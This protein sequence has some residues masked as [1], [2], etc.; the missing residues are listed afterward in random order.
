MGK[1]Y[2]DKVERALQYIYYENKGRSLHGK[3]GFQLLSDASKAGDGDASCVLARC[4]SGN[5]YV[6][7]GF[8]FPED[9][10]KADAL[11]RQSVEQGS[12]LGMLVAI[13]CGV[14]TKELEQKASM[15]LQDAFERILENAEGG[16]AFSQFVIGNTYFWWDFLRIQQK[17]AEDFSSH[18]EFRDYLKANITQCEDWFWK[19]FRGGIYLAGN[20]LYH[21]YLNGD[22]DIVAPQPDKAAEIYKIGAE[23]GYPLHQYF[24]AKDL[25]EAGKLE[26]A[27]KWYRKSAEGG[28]PGVWYN[29]GQWYQE[30]KG[31]PAD[32][33]EALCC[34]EKSAE[35]HEIGGLNELGERYYF[36]IGGFPKDPV[37]AFHYFIEAYQKGNH[38]SLPYLS[39]CYL[40]GWGTPPDYEKAYHL[41]WESKDW[42]NCTDGCYVLGRLYCEGL[43][44]P[45]DIGKGVEFLQRIKDRAPEAQEE[46]KKYKKGLFGGWKRR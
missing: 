1:F 41:A 18:N 13:R 38:F 21:Y 44:L 42:S 34:F 22:E 17:S 8:H 46:L 23:L 14:L 11:Y 39:R 37:K 36:G 24:Y 45:M 27:R 6:W 28:Q 3:E 43:G 16:D 10:E 33:R 9:E 5:Q 25:E 15:T 26:E 29:L 35:N 32:E 20:N 19:A 40:E 4:F 7:S 31:G 12:A 2:S 30:G